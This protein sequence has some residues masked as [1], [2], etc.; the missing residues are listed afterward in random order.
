MKFSINATAKPTADIMNSSMV[1]G[2]FPGLLK[3]GIVHPIYK[4]GVRS[5]F[6]NYRP[7]SV[8]PSFSKIF[9]KGVFNRLLHFLDSNNILCNN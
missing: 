9:E 3:L 6:H 8:L 2:V 4:N 1:N 7:I 5:D